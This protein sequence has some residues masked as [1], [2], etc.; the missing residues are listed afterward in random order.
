MSTRWGHPPIAWRRVAF[1]RDERV[2]AYCVSEQQTMY[3]ATIAGM[4]VLS[5]WRRSPT[6][7][8]STRSGQLERSQRAFP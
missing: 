1:R 5:V 4:V 2:G 6:I 7:W 8:T 3:F